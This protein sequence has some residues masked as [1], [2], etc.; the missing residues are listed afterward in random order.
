MPAPSASPKF[1]FICCKNVIRWQ[2]AF[3]AEQGPPMLTLS[4][5]NKITTSNTDATFCVRPRR[6]ARSWRER[7]A[8]LP[9]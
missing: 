6:R 2:L 8:Y 7:P 9:I 3:V 4:A 5:T 1:P